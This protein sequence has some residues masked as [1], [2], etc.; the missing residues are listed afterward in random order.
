M[1]GNSVEVMSESDASE[2]SAD[3]AAGVAGFENDLASLAMPPPP[4]P[5][6]RLFD[7]DPALLR[8]RARAAG[9]LEGN[10]MLLRF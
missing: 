4:S 8:E 7:A 9:A 1:P 5:P 2:A 10:Q 3:R 6:A